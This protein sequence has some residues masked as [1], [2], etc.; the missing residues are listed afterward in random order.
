MGVDVRRALQERGGNFRVK[1]ERQEDDVTPRERDLTGSHSQL[2]TKR[3][4]GALGTSGS[5]GGSNLQLSFDR[6]KLGVLPELHLGQVGWGL[7]QTGPVEGVPAHGQRVGND[8]ISKVPSNPNY[9]GIQPVGND[10]P[11]LH[12]R[13]N[14]TEV[15]KVQS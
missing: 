1:E 7:E 10:L 5:K 12:E 11:R 6:H 2:D 9:P 13:R 8:M 14:G 3:W 15:Y 4:A